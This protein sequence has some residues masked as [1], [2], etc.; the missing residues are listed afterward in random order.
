[1]K[2]P[3]VLL[4]FLVGLIFSAVALYFSFRNVPLYELTTSV[5]AMD[6]RWIIAS[7]LLGLSTYLV[8]A[9]RW[10]IILRPVRKIGFWH[11][12]H[13][14][15]IAF[16]IN[17]IL[18]GRVGELA[19]PAILYKRDDI[20]FSKTLTTVVAERLFDILIMLA[21]FIFIVGS[22]KMEPHMV[23]TFNGHPINRETLLAVRGKTLL[24]G[25]MLLGLAVAF[26][27]PAVRR[28]IVHAVSRLPHL[29]FFTTSS[30]RKHLSEV[31]ALRTHA[32]LDNASLGF[33][34]F[35]SPSGILACLVLSVCI[36][37]ITFLSFHVLALG[38]PGVDITFLQASAVVIL[39]C[40]FIMLPSVPGFWGIW[41]IGGIYGLMLFGV[42]KPEAA[43]LTL[44][45]H[46]AQI[47]PLILAGL[48]SAWMT[49]TNIL[50][51]YGAGD[52]G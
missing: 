24:A 26:M 36:W 22:I 46:V 18:P 47:I 49:G 11:A 16:M 15:A 41:E 50:R 8:R 39:T 35:R 32:A 40:F 52:K 2:D 6:Y 21:L 29:L 10:Q 31:M 51:S 28:S 4:S 13:P 30:Y 14:L 1:L 9:W 37:L 3:R 38:Y 44:T 42:P 20:E 23:L 45:F 7:V 34:V 5:M 19:R 43:G 33:E 48:V 17:C 27:L 12:Y 25:I